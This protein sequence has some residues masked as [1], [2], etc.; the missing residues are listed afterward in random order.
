MHNGPTSRFDT[1]DLH[2][3]EERELQN[4]KRAVSPPSKENKSQR[5]PGHSVIGKEKYSTPFA[6]DE[7]NNPPQF[8]QNNR[9]GTR[10]NSYF[11]RDNFT[12]AQQLM[13]YQQLMQQNNKEHHQE[14]DSNNNN[15]SANV[16]LNILHGHGNKSGNQ[17]SNS[18]PQR[19]SYSNLSQMLCVQELEARIRH[20]QQI[21]K[22]FQI[23]EQYL[24]GKNVVDVLSVY[25][26]AQQQQQAEQ[27]SKSPRPILK[28]AHVEHPPMARAF[29]I[30][31]QM[32][33]NN[34]NLN[35]FNPQYW[36][37]IHQ[38]QQAFYQQHQQQCP[39]QNQRNYRHQP[40]QRSKFQHRT[41]ARHVHFEEAPADDLWPEN[42]LA[43]FFNN[44]KVVNQAQLDLE[45][46]INVEEFERE[47]KAVTTEDNG[48]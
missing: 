42:N 4:F 39:N 7:F 26:Q 44:P 10:F 14:F 40:Q 25:A 32:Q 16:L 5:N 13:Q 46:I 20:D 9:Y 38:R 3:F 22:Q 23:N 27:M 48:E 30:Q 24:A 45:K 17:Y 1:I 37:M 19:T 2:G 34:P 6:F 31:R 33:G 47:I 8:G 36:A 29:E 12:E 28:N 21:L 18:P 35:P 41:N 15:A 43:Q 11:Q